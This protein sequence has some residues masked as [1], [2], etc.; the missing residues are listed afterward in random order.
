MTIFW[1]IHSFESFLNEYVGSLPQRSWITGTRIAS[2][3][4]IMQMA[5]L[6]EKAF[7]KVEKSERN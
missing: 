1:F 6:G 3:P 4:D 7:R 2:V 5:I